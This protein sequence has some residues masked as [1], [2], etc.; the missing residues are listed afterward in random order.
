M[1]LRDM[2][3][4]YAEEGLTRALAASRVCQD[5]VL[6]ALAEGPLRLI[7]LMQKRLAMQSVTTFRRKASIASFLKDILFGEKRTISC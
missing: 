6:K 3:D 1:N 2:M 5:I 7:Y 4:E